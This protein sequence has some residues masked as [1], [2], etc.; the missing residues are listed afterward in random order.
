L[1]Q[2]EATMATTEFPT[3][4]GV[5]YKEISLLLS[6]MTR[7]ATSDAPF[8]ILALAAFGLSYSATPEDVESFS[9]LLQERIL[10]IGIQSTLIFEDAEA[11]GFA[12]QML[13]HPSFWGLQI[14]RLST[15][16]P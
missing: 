6:A 14:K 8:Y 10:S 11:L 12:A 2:E 4:L 13:Q 16:C 3:T 1:N 15:R 5:E 7:G 9:S